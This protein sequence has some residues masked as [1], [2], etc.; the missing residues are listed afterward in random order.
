MGGFSASA[1]AV[2]AFSVAAFAF[3]AA[4]ETPTRVIEEY[5]SYGGGGGGD[6]YQSVEVSVKSHHVEDEEEIVMTI[7]MRVAQEYFA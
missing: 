2:V 4:P 3:D 5:I 1:F 6:G 7:L